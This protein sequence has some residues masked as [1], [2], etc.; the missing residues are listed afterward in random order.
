MKRDFT[1]LQKQYKGLWVALNEK[2]EKVIASDKNAKKA[3]DKAVKLGQKKPMLFKVPQENV[4]Y[5]GAF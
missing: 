3:Y 2:M 4:P 5:F 1:E